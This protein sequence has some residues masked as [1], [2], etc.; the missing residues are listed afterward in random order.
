MSENLIHSV[1][2]ENATPETPVTPERPTWLPEKFKTGEDLAKS[3]G[4]LE[5][6]FGSVPDE[7]D[8]SR[9]VFLDP[10][11]DVIK[12]LLASAKE[13]RVPKEFM[14]KMVDSF[15]KYLGEYDVDISSEAAKLGDNAKER[16]TLLDN[17]AKA[18]LTD[19]SYKALINNLQNAEAI[20]ALEE[21]RGKMMSSTTI[22]PGNNDSMDNN[23]ENAETIKQ[24]IV[25]NYARYKTDEKYRKE[26][27]GRLHKVAKASGMIDKVGA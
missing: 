10:D 12:D 27:E 1:I 5:K 16:L 24:E 6:K 20:H 2:G 23:V 14:D 26:V 19:K 17:W 13:K 11:K 18:N 8:I 9:S 4:E 25:N 22:V 21:L 7:Y 15:D 3:Y